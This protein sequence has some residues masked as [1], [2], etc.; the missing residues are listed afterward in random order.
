MSHPWLKLSITYLIPLAI[1]GL[2]LGVFFRALGIGRADL[3]T[4]EP[5][6]AEIA[7]DPLQYQAITVHLQLTNRTNKTI[8]IRKADTSC[9]CAS[10]V[11]RGGNTLVEPLDVPLEVHFHGRS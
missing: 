3:V 9:G 10:L 2:A 7:V 11:T 8:Q 5:Q 4:V 6:I 1:L